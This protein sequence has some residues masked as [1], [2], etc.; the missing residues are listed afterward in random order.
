MRPAKITDEKLLDR[1]TG[2]FRT[3]GYEGASLSRLVEATGLQR[4]SLYHRF[5]GGKSEM[6]E[7]VLTWVDR[8]FVEHVFNP[9]G[10]PGPAEERV[11]RMADALSKFY[12]GGRKPCLLNT[13][14][15]GGND[16]EIGRHV[17]A[18]FG[19][20]LESMAAVARESGAE[21][22]E[23]RRRAEE[24]LIGIQGA[25][26]LVRIEGDHAP[27]ERILNSL[28]ALLSGGAEP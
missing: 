24:A 25:L 28:P 9:L 4:A 23:A 5:P 6:A 11:R 1:L 17:R 22:A 26:V 12:V 13:L 8:W 19:A 20:W 21:A 14:S 2:V 27:F 7:A 16:N 15:L 18:S 10:G 3:H